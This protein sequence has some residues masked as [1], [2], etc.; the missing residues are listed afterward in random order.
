MYILFYI[1]CFYSFVLIIIVIY[2]SLLL[3]IR[4]NI[5]LSFILY[6]FNFL[7]FLHSTHGAVFLFSI[8]SL[9]FPISFLGDKPMHT[10]LAGDQV[11]AAVALTSER[12][13][14]LSMH[15]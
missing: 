11:T 2:V 8:V 4:A 12:G 14:I 1:L 13:K 10:L 3:L 7:N 6:Y 15:F 9:I 5:F